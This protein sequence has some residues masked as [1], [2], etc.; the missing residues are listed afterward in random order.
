MTYIPLVRANVIHGIVSLLRQLNLPIE[1]RLLAAKLPPSI[2]HDPEVLIPL[3]QILKLTETIAGTEGIEHFGLLA[4]QQTQIANLGAFGRLLCHSMTLYGAIHTLT[5]LVQRYNSGDQV[6]LVQQ[7][8]KVWLC[9]RFIHD[10]EKAYPQAVF[11]SL[12]LLIHVVRL[13]AGSEWKP[14]EIRLAAPPPTHFNQIELFAEAKVWFNQDQT[15][16]AFPATFLHAPLTTFS[17]ESSRTA[18]W[19][20]DYD[21]LFTL[22]PGLDFPTSLKQTI[23]VQLKQGYPNI[24]LTAEILG[25]SV[26]SLQRQLS[27]VN[28]TYSQLIDQVRFERSIQLLSNPFY[29]VADIAIEIGY[30]DP[31]NF[32][33]AFKRWAGV[34]PKDYAQQ[35]LHL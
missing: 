6:W 18:Y 33:R 14:T 10:W 8:E 27:Y 23:A 22:A 9:R 19:T 11:Y 32:T 25:T 28:M 34:P 13:G 15:A 16:I 35:Y 3:K 5:R 7:G 1:E 30:T 29:K 20:N 12:M 2:L 31:A 26:R 24:H 21:I 17:R 4:G